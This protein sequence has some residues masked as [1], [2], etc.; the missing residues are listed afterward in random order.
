[1]IAG[2]FQIEEKFEITGR[3]TAVVISQSTCLPVG[4]M[5]QATIIY[6]DGSRVIVQASKEWL[7]KRA[8]QPP[9]KEAYLLNGI[10]KAQ[11]PEGSSIEVAAI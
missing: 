2:P 7:L 4:K 1:M 6:P 3:G 5:L 9:E 8:S 10:E 11:I